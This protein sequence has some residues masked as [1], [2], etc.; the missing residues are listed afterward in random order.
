[1]DPSCKRFLI[2]FGIEQFFSH[3]EA[4]NVSQM[5]EERAE[6][7]ERQRRPSDP[8]WRCLSQ[9]DRRRIDCQRFYGDA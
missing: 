1:M 3:H 5:I 2:L 9:F 8:S 6:K 7:S 4:E